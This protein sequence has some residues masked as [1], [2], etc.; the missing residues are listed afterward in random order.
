[1]DMPDDLPEAPQP[2]DTP[3]PAQ[4]E[5]QLNEDT[6]EKADVDGTDTKGPGC[7]LPVVQDAVPEA[8]SG[9]QSA[10]AADDGT[11]AADADVEMHEA[12]DDDDMGEAPQADTVGGDTLQ[13]FFL[14]ALY[15][16]AMVGTV[17]L[18]GKVLQGN[19][20]VS[21]CVRAKDMKQC[22]YIVPKPFVFQDTEGDI[23]RYGSI[24]HVHQIVQTQQHQIGVY[25]FCDCA[26][27]CALRIRCSYHVLGASQTQQR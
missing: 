27:V 21:A 12:E 5:D 23:E 26:S 16:P 17:L 20:Y 2:D 24:A 19:E 4:P 6:A 3:E 22:V 18:I 25:A 15:E 7:I 14:D 9:W 13:F 1:M 11:T 10:V 8:A